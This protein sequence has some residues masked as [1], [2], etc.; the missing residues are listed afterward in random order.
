MVVIS[1]I[2]TML[3]EIRKNWV[4]QTKVFRVALLYDFAHLFSVWLKRKQLDSHRCFCI[5]S[6]VMSCLLELL[7]KSTVDSGKRVKKANNNLHIIMKLALTSQT[8]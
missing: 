3:F 4:F 7:E 2:D 5:Q 8:P 1:N 6:V